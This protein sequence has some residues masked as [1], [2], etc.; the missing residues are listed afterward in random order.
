[1]KPP[2]CQVVD[3]TDPDPRVMLAQLAD[4]A[5]L[6]VQVDVLTERVAVLKAG[7]SYTGP[8]EAA[9]ERQ[10]AAAALSELAALHADDDLGDETE[11]AGLLDSVDSAT[12]LVRVL[13]ESP[14]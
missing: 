5:R 9:S 7:Q 3:C 10:R 4:R 8:S 12:K 11:G 2:D 14:L 13:Q 6:L 1:M